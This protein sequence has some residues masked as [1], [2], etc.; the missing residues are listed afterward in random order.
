MYSTLV[1]PPTPVAT[2]RLAISTQIRWPRLNS[3]AVAMISIAYSL[4]SSGATGLR[5]ARV[6]GCHGRPGSDRF[7]SIARWDALSQPRVSFPFVQAR[8]V[9]LAFA[10]GLHAHVRTDVLENDD[11]ISVVLVDRRV[12]MKHAR[13]GDGDIFGQWVAAITQLLNTVGLARRHLH[14]GI[15]RLVIVRARR[16]KRLG[17]EPL[18]AA[19]IKLDPLRLWGRPIT[20]A[21]P[22]IGAHDPESHRWFV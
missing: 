10:R 16:H 18:P 21:A 14:E 12:E 22:F 8:N 4:I 3:L 20:G 19:Q 13:A 5:A 2:S 11:P 7:A 9:A 6:S 15:G 17:G 1:A